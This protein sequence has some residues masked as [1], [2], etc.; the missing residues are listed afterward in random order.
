[1]VDSQDSTV[2][3]VGVEEELWLADP[4]TRQAAP[5]AGRVVRRAADVVDRELFRHQLEIQSDP[6][7]ALDEVVA[8]LRERRWAAVK[9][10][11]DEG[12]AVVASGVPVLP[13]PDDVV[14]E[15][16]RYHDMLGRYGDVARAGGTCGMHVHVGIDSPEEGVH[17]LD[18]I[19]P[20]LP[21]VL[22]MT[23]NSPFA[24]GRDTGYQSWRSE[25]WSRWPSAGPAEAFGSEEGYRAATEALVRAGAARD[26]HMVY[27]DARLSDDHPTLEVRVAD[28]VTD[29]QEAGLV[30]AVVRG[31]VESAV[32]GALP[33]PCWRAELLRAARWRAA[34]YGLTHGLLH[35]AHPGSDPVTV[36][37]VLGDLVELLG[38]ALED[39]G[40]LERVRTGLE[41][42][43][44][45]TGAQR[46]H[47]VHEGTGSLERV[48]DD[49]VERTRASCEG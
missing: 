10:A 39:A 3:S 45:G 1:M 12:L 42:V 7:Q 36:R 40:D 27:F 43:L 33:E 48:V 38:P 30:A 16:D 37:E 6:H 26:P 23:T 31:L 17:V 11:E 5:G 24:G 49:L 13:S 44:R 15:D 28:V 14:T 9:A 41:R 18:R 47:A 25:Q 29:V 4:A 8:D 19:G 22:A 35:P 21:L 34:R 46:Q 20:W 2:R 32:R